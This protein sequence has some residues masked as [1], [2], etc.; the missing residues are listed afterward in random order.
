[1][2]SRTEVAAWE[3]LHRERNDPTY[4]ENVL[5]LIEA[6]QAVLVDDDHQSA[7][8]TVNGAP[9][10]RADAAAKPPVRVVLNAA[11]VPA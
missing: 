7:G 8:R 3:K 6:G 5:P 1:M 10:S 4:I 11:R 9:D 2:L